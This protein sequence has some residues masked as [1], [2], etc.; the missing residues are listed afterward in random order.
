MHLLIQCPTPHVIFD[1]QQ[2]GTCLFCVQQQCTCFY[3][4][5][6]CGSRYFAFRDALKQALSSGR[7]PALPETFDDDHPAFARLMRKAWATDPNERPTFDAIVFAF[8][9]QEP[10]PPAQAEP[11]HAYTAISVR[12]PAPRDNTK[13]RSGVPASKQDELMEPLLSPVY[14]IAE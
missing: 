12:A 14:D 5:L 1:V 2:Q 6:T 11:M 10:K 9:M 13:P 7:R 3:T 8:D 4:L